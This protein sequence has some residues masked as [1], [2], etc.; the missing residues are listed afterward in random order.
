MLAQSG[1]IQIEEVRVGDRNLVVSIA[2]A[3]CGG[4]LPLADVS[5][6]CWRRSWSLIRT[7][8]SQ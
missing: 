2:L 8:T 6:R 3:Y 7:A 5:D 4:I 1:R